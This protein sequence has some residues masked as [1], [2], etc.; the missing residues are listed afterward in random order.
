MTYRLLFYIDKAFIHFGI[1]KFLQEKYDCEQF[2]IYDFN[3]LQKKDFQNQHIVNFKKTWFLQDHITQKRI[4]PDL[5]Y[6][7]NFEKKYKIDLWLTV[8]N[9][10]IFYK[11][12]KFYKFKHNEILSIL[13][14]ECRF[15]E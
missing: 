9:E 4:K 11:Y 7:K 1:A 8:Y 6:L 2:V 13:E 5:D 15:F 14:Q 10:R 3:Y 12:N